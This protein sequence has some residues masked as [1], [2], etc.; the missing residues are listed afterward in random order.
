M[1]FWRATAQQDSFARS[2]GSY[3]CSG[4][5]LAAKGGNMDLDDNLKKLMKDLGIAIN[6]SLSESEPISEAISNIRGAGYDVFL[7]L[8][9]TIGFN[10]RE[11]EEDV[12]ESAVPHFKSG[13]LE[14]TNQDAKFLK[15]LKISFEEEEEEK[16]E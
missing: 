16:S 7:V 15:S 14:L 4:N 13:I 9:A 12:D 10:K 8:E 5:E 1:K 11:E 2:A 6:E 3:S